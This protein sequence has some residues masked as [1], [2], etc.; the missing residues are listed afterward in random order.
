MRIEARLAAVEDTRAGRRTVGW[1][2]CGVDG[3]TEKLSYNC[4]F[5]GE[6]TVDDPRWVFMSLN[7]VHS[8]GIQQL[9]AHFACL[10]A[11]LR[12]GFPLDDGL[13]C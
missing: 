1:H 9:G 8:E 13:E 11:A 6:D 4:G 7:W 12:P 3:E 2:T 10:Q 5:C